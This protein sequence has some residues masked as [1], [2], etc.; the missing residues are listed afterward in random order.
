[1]ASHADKFPLTVANPKPA[2]WTPP[3]PGSKPVKQA[4]RKPAAAPAA[5]GQP[6]GRIRVDSAL[7]FTNWDT[8]KDGFVTLEEFQLG[9]KIRKGLEDTFKSYDKNG[10]G[11]L[12]REEYVDPRAK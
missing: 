10:D 1:M 7:H 6:G 8:N 2:E 11:K 4:K 3:A 5:A 12:S 9:Q